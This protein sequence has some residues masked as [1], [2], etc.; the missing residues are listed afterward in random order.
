MRHFDRFIQTQMQELY[1][2][3]APNINSGKYFDRL[4]THCAGSEDYKPPNP[5]IIIYKLVIKD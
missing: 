3:T 1:E 4:I 5:S 2:N